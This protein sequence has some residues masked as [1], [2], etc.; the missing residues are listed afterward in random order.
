MRH[1]RP[2]VQ[3]LRHSAPPTPNPQPPTAILERAFSA[4]GTIMPKDWR[5]TLRHEWGSTRDPAMREHLLA[6]YADK[7]AALSERERENL[8]AE[9]ANLDC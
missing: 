9:L 1:G 7:I 4:N 8:L 2:R 6:I 3:P 5:E